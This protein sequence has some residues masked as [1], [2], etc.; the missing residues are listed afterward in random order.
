[1]ATTNGLREAILSTWRTNDRVTAFLLE[2][3]PDVVWDMKVPEAPRRTVRMIA[4]H[5][6]NTRCMWVKTLGR[7]HGVT[8]PRGVNRY[9]VTRSQLLRALGRSHRS[10]QHL[11]E[12]GLARDGRLPGFP[13]DVVHFMAYL[14]AHEAHHRGQILMLARQLLG[15]RLPAEVSHGLWQWSKRA[16]EASRATSARVATPRARPPR[17]RAR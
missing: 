3:L 10:V 4:G 5:I 17:P 1:M 11:I 16:G 8:V 13:P 7:R 12:L 2:R 6:H 9:R 15:R 14:V